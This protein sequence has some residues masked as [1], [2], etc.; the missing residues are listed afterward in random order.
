MGFKLKYRRIGTF[1]IDMAIVQMF[2][3][4]GRD[5]YLGVIAYISDGTGMTLSLND[6]IALPALLLLFI[7]LM[8]L[9]IGVFMGYQ[10]I[11]YRLLGTSLS[12]YLLSVQVVSTDDKSL[13]KQ[14]YLKREF[15]K[16]YLCVATLGLY[17]LYSGAQ[18][19]AFSNPPMH[20]RT[21]HTTVIEG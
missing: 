13:T 6:S 11:C 10:W 17:P 2:A 7:G 18:Y 8:L 5:I 20:D 4:V 15:N 12:R 9:F 14:R 1:M 16:I 19:L 3:M 21:N